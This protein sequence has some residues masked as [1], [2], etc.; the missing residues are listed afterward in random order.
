MP[1]PVFTKDIPAQIINELASYGPFDFNAFLEHPEG[2]SFTFQAGL[3]S[4][5]P[6]PQGMICT[7]DGYLTGIPAKGTSGDYLILVTASNE[8]GSSEARFTLHIKPSIA[9]ETE[10]HSADY[11]NELKSKIWDAIEHKKPIPEID[12]FN[13]EITPLDVYY[14]LERWGVLIIYDAFNLEPPGEKKLLQLEGMSEQYN[15][16]D[17]GS[18]LVGTPKDL[19][20][21][22]RTTVDALQTAR[23]MAKE[24]Y[25]RN[26]TIELVGFDKMTRAAWVEIQHLSEQY[27]RPLEIINYQPTSSDIH[28]YQA[29]SEGIRGGVRMEKRQD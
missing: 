7:A 12:F 19:F 23:V 21:H 24:A 26:W 28:I 6:L 2:V 22:E 3:E 4:G 9:Q 15:I 29:E 18:C 11:F 16:Y 8:E 1:K 14:L 27:G 13:Q 10:A 25:K 20:S 5:E 17:R